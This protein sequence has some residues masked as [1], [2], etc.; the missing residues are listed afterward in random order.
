MATRTS[1]RR[2]TKAAPAKTKPVEPAEEELEELEEAEDFEEVEEVE[3]EAA[4]AKGVKTRDDAVVFGVADLARH[5][6]QKTGK[7]VTTRE[8]RTLIRKMARDGG[9]RVNR[10]IVAGNRSRYDW[11]NGLKDPEVRAIIAAYTSGEGEEAKRASLQALQERNA[12]KRAEAAA[13]R[14]TAAE[15]AKTK[16]VA[17]KAA[18]KKPAPPVEEVDEEDEELDFGDE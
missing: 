4:P 9:G 13:E 1:A 18:A 7:D 2:T 6:S 5:L 8:L 11:P 12:A 10:E 16:P 14:Q 15:A 3:P 17:K